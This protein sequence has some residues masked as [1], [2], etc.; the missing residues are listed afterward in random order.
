[1][2]VGGEKV[3]EREEGMGEEVGVR[4]EDGGRGG[5]EVGVK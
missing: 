5:G 1:M 2:G 3:M 4:G